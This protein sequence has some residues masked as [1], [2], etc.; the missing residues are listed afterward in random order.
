MVA[1]NV[2]AF[3]IIY[4]DDVMIFAP[5]EW[6]IGVIRTIEALWTCKIGGTMFPRLQ[7]IGRKREYIRADVLNA[8]EKLFDDDVSDDFKN[9]L[10]GQLHF[11]GVT[12]EVIG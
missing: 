2:I 3:F 4:V 10:Q 11:L 6:V 1:D 12:L 7:G 8:E 5:P 9:M